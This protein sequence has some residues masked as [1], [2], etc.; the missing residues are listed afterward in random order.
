MIK[1]HYIAIAKILDTEST[2]KD[3][4]YKMADY[5]A[6]D[7]PLFDKAKFLKACGITE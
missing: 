3:V 7:N 6:S 4:M 5:F 2:R 1:K